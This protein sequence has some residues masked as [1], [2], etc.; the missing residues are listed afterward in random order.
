MQP[1][2]W[3]ELQDCVWKPECFDTTMQGTSI[4]EFFD[5]LCRGARTHGHDLLKASQFKTLLEQAGFVDVQEVI[6]YN[7]G[8]PW[9]RDPKMKQIGYYVSNIRFPL[10]P[11]SA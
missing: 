11:L 9:Q 7:G 3:I 1:G 8:S 10:L 4:P 5:R 6:V 2:G